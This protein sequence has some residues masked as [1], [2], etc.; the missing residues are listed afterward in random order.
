LLKSSRDVTLH[1]IT[2]PA[3]K[4]VFLVDGAAN[5]DERQFPNPDQ[6]DVRRGRVRHLGFGEGMLGCLGAPLASPS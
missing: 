2:I 6:F 3:G 1:G 4:R 5:P